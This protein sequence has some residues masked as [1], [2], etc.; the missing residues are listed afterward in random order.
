MNTHNAYR[1]TST[2]NQSPRMIF[3]QHTSLR[4]RRRQAL[5][6]AGI[7]VF[8]ITFGFIVTLNVSEPV[9]TIAAMN[10]T[11]TANDAAENTAPSLL[12]VSETNCSMRDGKI[13]LNYSVLQDMPVTISVIAQ[14]GK[15]VYNTTQK[16]VKG[17]NQFTSADDCVFPEG[18]YFATL[19][20]GD[21]TVI[22][23]IDNN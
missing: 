19:T 20:S 23:K 3:R 14:N 1:N 5:I 17:L 22:Q 7:S 18:T 16:A 13:C 11:I 15:E 9:K 21:V 10:E 6:G 12:S 4:S 2:Q 8:I